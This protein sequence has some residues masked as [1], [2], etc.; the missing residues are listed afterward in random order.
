MLNNKSI[1]VHWPFCLAKCPYCDFNSHVSNKDIQMDDWIKSYKHEI[2]KEIEYTDNK[3]IQSIFFGGGTPSLMPIRIIDFILNLLAKNYI[4]SNDCEITLEANPSSAEISKF[5]ILSKMGIN[6]LSIGLQSLEDKSLKFLGRNHNAYEGLQA[7]DNAKKYYKKVSF[8]LIYGLPGQTE[9][10]WEK[11]LSRAIKMSQGHISAYQLTIE[12]GT[13]FYAMQR[14]KKLNLPSDNTLLN[15]YQLTEKLLKEKNFKK[16]EVSNYA[17][18]GNEC[19]HN[20]N[21]WKGFEYSGFG[22]GAHGRIKKHNFWYENQRYSAPFLWLNKAKQK[23]N[24]SLTKKKISP[25]QRAKEILLTSLRLSAGADT[26]SIK[27]ICKLDSLSSVID[28]NS[29]KLLEKE[30]FIKIN[31]NII[32][33]TNKGF[34][35]LNSIINKIII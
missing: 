11:E 12:K 21:I 5:K 33:L 19:M 24:T 8:D 30:K 25:N 20:I 16:Y 22:P 14:D 34:P 27:N 31:K 28:K 4:I 18:N 32:A 17:L 15:L 10:N 3:N 1:Y 35:L 7:L 29:C 13:P 26:K 6:R 23:Q 2:Q 9:Q